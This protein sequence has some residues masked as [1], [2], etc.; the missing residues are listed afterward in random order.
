M[1]SFTMSLEYDWQT[2]GSRTDFGEEV[3]GFPNE[4]LS[5]CRLISLFGKHIHF[6]PHVAGRI[7]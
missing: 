3:Y 6:R 2:G 7:T 4:D 1:G 5:V